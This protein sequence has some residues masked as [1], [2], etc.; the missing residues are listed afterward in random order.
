MIPAGKCERIDEIEFREVAE[1]PDV[2]S[3]SLEVT[4]RIRKRPVEGKSVL[5]VTKPI[6]RR[7]SQYRLECLFGTHQHDA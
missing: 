2:E 6:F 4:Q 1:I 7:R 3:R 5:S